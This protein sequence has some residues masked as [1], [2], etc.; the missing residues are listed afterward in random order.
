[1]RTHKDDL[2]RARSYQRQAATGGW[3]CFRSSFRDW[4]AEATDYPGDV[5]E[6]ALS[7]TVGGKVEAAYRRGELFS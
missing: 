7:H 6:M 1:M 4:T 3:I 5:A 2:K